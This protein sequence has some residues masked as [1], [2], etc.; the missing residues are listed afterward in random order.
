MNAF[1]LLPLPPTLKSINRGTP[2]YKQ[3][4]LFSFLSYAKFLHTF[5]YNSYV[6]ICRDLQETIVL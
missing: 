2:L 3:Y 6:S 4:N 5:F 1:K